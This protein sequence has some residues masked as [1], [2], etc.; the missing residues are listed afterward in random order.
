MPR[1]VSGTMTTAY[2]FTGSA[3]RVPSL[4]NK[5]DLIFRLQIMFQLGKIPANDIS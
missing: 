3:D 4:D 5:A 2:T 1:L